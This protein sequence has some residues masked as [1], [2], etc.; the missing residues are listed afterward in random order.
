M[1]P[2]PVPNRTRELGRTG[3]EIACER[4]ACGFGLVPNTELGRLLGCATIDH[5]GSTYHFCSTGCADSFE[6]DP[7]RKR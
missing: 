2:L 7:A 4:L 6:A 1:P 5:H 3:E